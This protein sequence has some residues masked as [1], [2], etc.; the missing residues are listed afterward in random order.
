MSH[1]KLD[2]V[3]RYRH[4]LTIN[5]SV[6]LLQLFTV[7]VIAD[8]LTL[9]GDMLHSFADII[10]LLGTHRV[11]ANELRHPEG[12]HGAAKQLLVRGAVAL[13]WISA[14][15]VFVE[16]LERIA[17]PV[18]FPGW[19]V[20]FL[21]ILSATGNF[22]AH[23][24]ISGVDKREHDHA[25]EANIAHLLT[26]IALSVVVLISALGNILFRLPAI[27]AWLSLLVA[28]WMFR[29]GWKILRGE[30]HHSGHHH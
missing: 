24:Q 7:V 11:F 12:N 28:L 22:F 27:D 16:A 17:H 30:D 18:D 14:G 8:S 1:S 13:L 26:D 9:F 29:W 23:Q 19:P 20:V 6:W 21:A 3:R 15:Y 10:I 4:A 2:K 25:H 5:T